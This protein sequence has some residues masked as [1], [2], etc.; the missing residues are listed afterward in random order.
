MDQT[1]FPT[2]GNLIAA[3]NTLRLS[4]QGYELMDKK[5]NVLIREIMELNARAK[6]LQQNIDRVFTQAY[7][8][9]QK[10]NIEMGISNVERFSF[11]VP[12]EN[13]IRVK[14]RSIMGVEIPIAEY[15]NS[16]KDTPSFGFGNTTASLDEAYQKFNEVKD[17][18]I[19]LASIENTAYRLAINIKKTQK[20]ANALKNVTIPKYEN[21]VKTITATLE[22]RERD[23]FTRLKVIKKRKQG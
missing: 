6:D 1:T 18:T 13:T 7:A 15:D 16:T 2:K 14:T 23:E 8:A 22:E 9:L 17:L 19:S 3:K 4:K 11:G 12:R 5:R 20:R 10:A 21:L